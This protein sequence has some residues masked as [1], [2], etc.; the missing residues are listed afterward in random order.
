MDSPTSWEE[1]ISIDLTS[2]RPLY[3][4]VK[5]AL[6]DWITNGLQ[7]G[8]LCP[9]DRLPSENELSEKLKVSPITVKRALD[10]LRRQGLIQRIQGRGSFIAEQQKIYLPLNRLFS[11]THLTLQQGMTPARRTLSIAEQSPNPRLADSLDIGME[12]TVFKLVRMRLMDDNPVAVETTYLPSQLFPDFFAIYSDQ[13]SLYDL[14]AEHYHQE[15]VRAEDVVTP[16]LIRPN[17]ARLFEI[18]VGSLAILI[19]RLA[20]NPQNRPIESTKTVFR[21]DLVSFSI[22]SIKESNER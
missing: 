16:V 8:S 13:V 10:D 18:P 20:F 5:E 4:Q 14:L 11:L 6:E 12:D 3:M 15:A 7:D 1:E 19:Q 21:G 9:G 22:E 2:L 17:D